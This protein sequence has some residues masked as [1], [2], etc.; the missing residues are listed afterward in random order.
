[1]SVLQ[2]TQSRHEE[3]IWTLYLF[4]YDLAKQLYLNIIKVLN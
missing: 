1:M 4:R 3:P 2:E